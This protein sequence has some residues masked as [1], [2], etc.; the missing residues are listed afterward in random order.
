MSSRSLAG[1]WLA[2][3]L[4]GL[5]SCS[6]PPP[7]AQITPYLDAMAAPDETELP[8]LPDDW[9]PAPVVGRPDP[10]PIEVDP[11]PQ[12]DLT[13]EQCIRFMLPEWDLEVVLAHPSD[14]ELPLD[15]VRSVRFR[16]GSLVEF[17]RYLALRWDVDVSS[18]Y[19]GQIQ[20]S[21]RSLE[22]WLVTHWMEPPMGSGG[23]GISG[24][25]G[26][27]QSGGQSGGE[28]GGEQSQGGGG[29]GGISGGGGGSGGDL[30]ATVGESLGVLLRRLRELAGD[31][32]EQSEQS[33]WVNAEAGL[34]Y[35]WAA[36][37]ARRAMRPL[38][39]N[40]GARPIGTDPELIAMMTRGQF[41]M[42]LVLVRLATT[43][44]RTVGIQWEESLRTVFPAGRSLLGV[45]E[46]GLGG[47]A[48]EGRVSATGEWIVGEGGVSFGLSGG[49]S[50]NTPTFASGSSW[51]LANERGRQDAMQSVIAL[52]RSRTQ[53]DLDRV[54]TRINELE[55]L[56]ETA[57]TDGAQVV[58]GASHVAELNILLDKSSTL[59]NSIADLTREFGLAAVR[60]ARLDD[61]L[62][63][64]TK[65]DERDWMRSLSLLASLGSAHGDTEVKHEISIDV[66][67][68][69]PVVLRMGSERTYLAQVT[70]TI[71]Q[72][73]S[74]QAATPETRLEGLDLTM[75]PW[76]EG[77][78][79]I[80]VGLQL[81]NSGITS[82]A[83]F[84]VAGTEL[85][86]PQMA[87]QEW[88]SE[89]RLCDSRP[90]LLARFKLKTSV[91]SES[92]LPFFGDRQV[93]LSTGRQGSSEEYLLLLQA[94]LPAE[95]GLR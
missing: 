21:S 49:R 85:V 3:S 86:I 91:T 77:R 32:D 82:V 25:V 75:R 8:Q 47:V 48:R 57:A 63:R 94:L 12:A 35:I 28:Q 40:Y 66:R 9:V 72:T 92:G 61:W 68:G 20:V 50:R 45:P 59:Q 30:V 31:P 44:D 4:L 83:S 1:L 26:A 34:L 90:A 24:G 19:V 13:L 89:R 54:G 71:S 95:W 2:A 81:N 51:E 41:R 52:E 73:F 53:V 67:H 33:V 38:L 22:A 7:D 14:P 39:A 70:S 78:R 17:M 10:L 6:I 58:F 23:G 16:G 87:V 5:S 55:T 93:P 15:E 29:G 42:R 64:I 84:V 60:T 76:L 56:R 11:I 18:P 37:N 27:R 62:A 46:V 36:P 65:S 88:A 80:R 69:R 43:R 79:C 74:Q